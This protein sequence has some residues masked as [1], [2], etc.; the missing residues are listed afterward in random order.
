VNITAQNSEQSA[1]QG[2]DLIVAM[3]SLKIIYN[4]S[5]TVD[6]KVNR[7]YVDTASNLLNVNN[8]ISWRQVQE[9]STTGCS[10]GSRVF[11]N[12]VQIGE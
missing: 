12:G 8:A 2:R 10:G 3:E 4:H 7:L 6:E 5:N 11:Q 9:V 1:I